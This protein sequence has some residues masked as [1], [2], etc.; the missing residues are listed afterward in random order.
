LTGKVVAGN[1]LSELKKEDIIV[2]ANNKITINLPAPKILYTEL[3]QEK[4]QLLKDDLSPL[5][6]I[7]NISDSKR[8]E[9]NELLRKQVS[10]QA[11]VAL[12]DGACRSDIL[13]K[14]GENTKAEVIRIF[15]FAQIN[16]IE[17][18]V[19]GVSNCINPEL[20]E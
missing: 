16:G 13:A 9:L 2:D 15:T 10:K 12:F 8:I 19:K 7:E 3:D 11:R 18:N 1:D 17:V 14:A 20:S 6:R 5:F 4:T